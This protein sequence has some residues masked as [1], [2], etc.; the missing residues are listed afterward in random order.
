MPG[1]GLFRCTVG[2]VE[3]IGGSVKD[4]PVV[5]FAKACLHVVPGL[6][7]EEAVAVAVVIFSYTHIYGAGAP[8]SQLPLGGTTKS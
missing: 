1:T 7:T 3:I 4:Q 5:P 6:Q 8:A 2:A